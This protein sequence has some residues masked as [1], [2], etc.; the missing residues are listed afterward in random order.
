MHIN[1]TFIPLLLRSR[2]CIVHIGSVAA[3]MPYI[4]SSVYNASKAAL[5]AYANTLRV[6]L[7]PFGVH[8]LTVVT[9]GVRSNIARTLRP[10]PEGSLFKA[11]LKE[12][13]YRVTHSQTVGEDAAVYAERTV[14][15]VLGARGRW[16]N[17]NE[18][19]AGAL[20]R[21]VWWMQTLDWF[22]P[23]GV[24]KFVLPRLVSLKGKID[25]PESKKLV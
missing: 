2:G 5:H 7:A 13:E 15:G 25:V 1:S 21:L 8:V 18:V 6:E 3:L 12:Y 9:G 10:L 22:F 24:W 23:G 4:W 11:Q 20:W 17:S 14:K 19:W 16:W